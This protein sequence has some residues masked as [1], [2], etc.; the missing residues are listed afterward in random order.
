MRIISGKYGSRHLKAVPGNHTRPT[1]DIVKE[2]I[3]NMLGMNFSGGSVLDFYGGSG[4]LAIEAISRGMDHAVICDNYR[5]AIETIKANVSV[6]KEADRFTILAGDH[7]H[8]LKAYLSEQPSQ[9]DLIFLDPP[10]KQAA[11][12]KDVSFFEEIDCVK[13]GSLIVVETGKDT[14]LREEIGAFSLLKEKIYGESYIRIYQK[15][16]SNRE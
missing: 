9:F 11:I 10:Y 14:T 12:E 6:T 16:E 4:A 1:T 15:G 13:V 5:P 7:Y 2:S 3:F 8:R